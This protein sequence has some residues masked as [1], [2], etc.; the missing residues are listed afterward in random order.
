MILHFCI[1][2][3]QFLILLFPPDVLIGFFPMLLKSMSIRIH[4]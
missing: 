3:T 2:F 1:F 4:P